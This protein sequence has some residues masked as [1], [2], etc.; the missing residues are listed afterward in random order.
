MTNTIA[1][2]PIFVLSHHI[3]NPYL[4]PKIEGGLSA[5]KSRTP[6]TEP[7]HPK[8]PRTSTP[9]IFTLHEIN[10]KHYKDNQKIGKNQNVLFTHDSLKSLQKFLL[11]VKKANREL[12]LFVIFIRVKFY[13]D[14]LGLFGRGSVNFNEI[15]SGHVHKYHRDQAPALRVWH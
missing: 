7:H 15:I 2:V 10:S 12:Y 13:F 14:V 4:Y 1:L 9:N 3:P 6:K 11:I 5:V 8:T